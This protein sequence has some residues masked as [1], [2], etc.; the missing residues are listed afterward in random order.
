MSGL[1]VFFVR[2]IYMSLPS[3]LL[4]H[5]LTMNFSVQ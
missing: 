2:T 1:F 5:I 4:L 3:I